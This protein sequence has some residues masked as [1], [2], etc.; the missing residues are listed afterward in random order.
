MR[1]TGWS[2]KGLVLN[3]G[4]FA[5]TFFVFRLGLCPYLWRDLLRIAFERSEDPISQACIPWHF[6][7]FLLVFGIIFNCLN[8][9]WAVKIV[10]KMV[11][12]LSGVEKV[13]AN[14]DMKDR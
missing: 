14:N 12:K 6:K 10:K 9:F 1:F 13:Q 2:E 11:R 8:A 5:L 7:Y 3:M 4:L